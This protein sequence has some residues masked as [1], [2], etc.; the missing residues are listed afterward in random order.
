MLCGPADLTPSFPLAAAIPVGESGAGSDN[1]QLLQGE[2]AR[3]STYSR[4]RVDASPPLPA[5]EETDEAA[6]IHYRSGD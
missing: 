5:K 6:A 1:P 2:L 4:I 3:L